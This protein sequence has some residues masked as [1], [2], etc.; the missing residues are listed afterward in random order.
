MSNPKFD[1]GDIIYLEE[2]AKLGFLESYSIS[3][4]RQDAD[5]TWIYSISVPMRPPHNNMTYGDRI[6]LR[7]DIVFE[8]A[9][10][11]IIDFCDAVDLAISTKQ[12]ELS[13]LQ[14][15]KSIQCEDSGS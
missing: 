1:I 10:S 7:N 11:D 2:S 5:G 4:V 6:T 14:S 12:S 15:L 8:I 9:E 13:K 3:T